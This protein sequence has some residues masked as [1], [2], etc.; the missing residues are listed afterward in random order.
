MSHVLVTKRVLLTGDIQVICR[1]FKRNFPKDN[2]LCDPCCDDP[3][4]LVSISV[5]LILDSTHRKPRR[6]IAVM[7]SL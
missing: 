1:R 3:Y 4:W 6:N 2:K 7:D 5:L